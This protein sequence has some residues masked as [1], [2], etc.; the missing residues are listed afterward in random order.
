MHEVEEVTHGN[1]WTGT[2]SVQPVLVP[3]RTQE[4]S[5]STGSEDLHFKG[6]IFCCVDTKVFYFL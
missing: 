4:L 5:V 1:Q 3:K 6:V 2:E